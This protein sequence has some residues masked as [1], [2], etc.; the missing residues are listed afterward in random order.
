VE[1]ALTIR[2]LVSTPSLSSRLVAGAEGL[3]RRVLWAHSCELA[4]PGRWLAPGELLMTVGLCL[5]ETPAEQRTFVRE[6]DQAGLAGMAVGDHEL[7]EVTPDLLHEADRIGFPVMITKPE[8]P[9]ASIGRTVA[10]ANISEQAMDVLVLGKVYHL[11]GT[12]RNDPTALVRELGR[13]LGVRLEVLEEG[14]EVPVLRA[15][16]AATVDRARQRRYPLRGSH[17]AVLVVD[18]PDDAP[19]V[20]DSLIL[21]HLMKV[22]EV[23]ADAVIGNARYRQE[24]SQRL[25]VEIMTGR[26]SAIVTKALGPGVPTAGYRVVA[27]GDGAREPAVVALAMALSGLPV[28]CGSSAGETFVVVPDTNL[29]AI[30]DLLHEL[31]VPAGA[32]SLYRDLRDCV[33]A[34]G[35]ATRALSTRTSDCLWSDYEGVSISLL[36]RS[37]REAGEIVSEILG[38][39]VGDEAKHV[40]LRETLFAFLEHDRSWARTAAELGIHRQTL[41]H[42]LG[43]IREL[44]GRDTTRTADLSA[45]W[46]AR[47]GWLNH[48]ASS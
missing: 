7:A 36:T 6:L 41:A 27:V 18:E 44:T 38:P 10:A 43:R 32:S 4:H 16:T 29:G 48:F 35:E 23:E 47:E 42:R 1:K 46:L 2:D 24:R 40:V 17:P 14:S 33:T 22:L 12:H 3:D 45:L 11:A 5:P 39:L 31:G 8:T 25:F 30:K 21:T 20:I 26:P 15:D 13:L 34:A 19:I 37:R 28:L 9:F